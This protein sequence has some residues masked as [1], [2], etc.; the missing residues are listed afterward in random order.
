MW[1]IPKTF[2]PLLQGGQDTGA[3]CAHYD[4]SQ[5]RLDACKLHMLLPIGVKRLS[6]ASCMWL[7]FN[8]LQER[9]QSVRVA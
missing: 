3:V 2:H 9:S 7:T 5:D 1:K 6:Y 4:V 8:T